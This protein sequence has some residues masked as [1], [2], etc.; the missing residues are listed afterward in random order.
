[1]ADVWTVE[2]RQMVLPS[3]TGGSWSTM[4]GWGWGWGWDA[5]MMNEGGNGG[6]GGGE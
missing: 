1:M 5:G 6:G 3:H 4:E 2:G